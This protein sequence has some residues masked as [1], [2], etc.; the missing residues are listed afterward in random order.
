MTHHWSISRWGRDDHAFGAAGQ[1]SRGLLGGGEDAGGFDDDLGSGSA[2]FDVGR[3][4]F[5]KN[6]NF[7]PVNHEF[8]VTLLDGPVEFTVS[9]VVFEH[10]D[11]VVKCDKRIID[12]DNSNVFTIGADAADEAKS[13]C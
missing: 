6:G 7:I 2:P 9:R 1:V 4:S 3:V 11:H 12:S 8:T 13:V 5:G 10:V